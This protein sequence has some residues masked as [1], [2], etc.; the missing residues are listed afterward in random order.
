[1]NEK[2]RGRKENPGD[3][4][5]GGELGSLARYMSGEPEPAQWPLKAVRR[6]AEAL[7]GPPDQA[8]DAAVP[9]RVQEVLPELVEDRDQWLRLS[10]QLL[11]EEDGGGSG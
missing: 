7:S 4:A 3:D 5:S 11:E 6:I 2:D 8:F 10:R 1:M 9:G